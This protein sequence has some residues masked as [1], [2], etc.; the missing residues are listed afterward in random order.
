MNQDNTSSSSSHSTP[1]LKLG[2]LSLFCG[3]MG[4]GK[5]TKA[6][7]LSADTGAVLFVEDEWLASLF[8]EQ[9]RT[10]QDYIKYSRRI[11]PI[12]KQHVQSILLAG[13][14]VV[15]DFPAN[16]VAQRTWLFSI[17]S[18][19]GALHR[20]YYLDVDDSTCLRHIEKRR[21]EQP[22]RAATDT[23]E[24]FE[25]MAKYFVAPKPEEGFKLVYLANK[26]QVC[27]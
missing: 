1:H 2:E 23:A 11:K 7:Q 5:S 16:T 8:P 12:V 17:F 24:M 3:K 22:Q 21:I 20:L 10:L 14:S 6:K 9:V 15:M 4:A 18:E 13:T 27:L 19:I 26:Q 25:A